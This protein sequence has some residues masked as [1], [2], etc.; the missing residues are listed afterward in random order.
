MSQPSPHPIS[1]SRGNELPESHE[2]GHL[3]TPEI[4]PKAAP[5]LSL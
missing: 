5:S 4:A 1:E 2:G 3:V